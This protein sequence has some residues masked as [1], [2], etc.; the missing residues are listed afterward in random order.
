M[1]Q[2]CMV[3]VLITKHFE[4]SFFSPDLTPPVLICP[5][6]LIQPLVS[7]NEY[8]LQLNEQIY[9]PQV[10]SDDSKQPVQLE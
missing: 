9:P 3:N 2:C 1:P 6:S 10:A 4:C 7:D 8:T 5:P